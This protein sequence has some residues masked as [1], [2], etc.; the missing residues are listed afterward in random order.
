MGRRSGRLEREEEKQNS[1][2][3]LG[4]EVNPA[5]GPRHLVETDIVKPL[6]TGAQ[7]LTHAV[8]RHEKRLLPAHEDVFVLCVVLVVEVWF[9][10]RFG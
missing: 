7:N 2:L 3:A 8:V 5:H 4:M 1:L 6:E 9:L 10:G